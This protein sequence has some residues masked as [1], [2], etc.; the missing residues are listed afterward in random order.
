MPQ[1]IST[2]DFDAKVQELGSV[3]AAMRWAQENGYKVNWN[4]ASLELPPVPGR[5]PTGALSAVPTQARAAAPSG[6][7]SVASEDTGEEGGEETA[8]PSGGL[9]TLAELR[10]ELLGYPAKKKA[11]RQ[12]AFT[13]GQEYIAQAY[14]GPSVSQQ[15][16]ALSKALL[17]PKKYSGFAGTMANVSSALSDVAK[18]QQEAKQKRALAEMELRGALDKGT[19]DDYYNALKLRY[20][21]AETEAEALAKANKP[22]RTVG[23]QVVGGQVVAVREDASGNLS[24]VP[25]GAAPANLKPIPGQTS[26]GQPVF[27][28]PSGPVDAAGNP[29]KEFDVKA[30]PVSATEQREIFET[31]DVI[32]SGLSTVKTLE[33]AIAL[34]PQAYE[35]SLTGWRKTLGQLVSSD[36]PQYVAT[37]NFDNLVMTGALQSLKATFGANPTE[38]ERK[39]LLDLQ[40]ISNKPRAVRDEILRRALSAAKTRVSRESK[41]LQGLKGGEYSTRGGTTAGETRVIRYDKSG[42][43]I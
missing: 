25:L 28:G 4:D 21:I 22:P 9:S 38:G 3:G 14:A 17:S 36:D 26:G 2:K 13:K 11:E 43:R 41:R 6:G 18:S 23:T 12:E 1:V 5:E 42:K 34:N 16:F 20:D 31:E 33:D 24:T 7:L 27:M 15:L 39:I 40:A 29:V 35:G 32:N 8:K 19:A 37:E 30:K 10:S